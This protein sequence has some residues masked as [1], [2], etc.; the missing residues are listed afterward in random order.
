[1]TI[2]PASPPTPGA[3]FGFGQLW[4]A[5][6]QIPL[7]LAVQEAC[8][9]IGAVTGKGL[10]GVIKDHYSRAVL[11][12]VVLIVVAANT[13]NVGADIAA[14]AEASA[15]VVPVPRWLLAV[16][17]AAL[18]LG[19]EIFICYANYAKFLKWLPWRS[20]LIPPRRCS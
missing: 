13:I 1:M 19:L 15:L 6:Y 20:S 18:V 12:G 10:A 14:V 7:L 9:R 11:I 4:T 17:T 5:C 2:P 8:A 3:Q 16:L